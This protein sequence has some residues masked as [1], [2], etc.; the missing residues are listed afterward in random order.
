MIF[1]RLQFGT[2]LS[3]AT[4]L[5]CS[6]AA[7]QEATAEKSAFQ[8]ADNC[9]RC[10]RAP[11]PKDRQN[12]VTDFVR[13]TES[14]I[15][16]GDD[17]HALAFKLID[18]AD[19]LCSQ[20]AKRMLAILKIDDI[21][22]ARQCLSCHANWLPEHP[23][24]PTL[25]EGVTCESCHGPSA[26]WEGPHSKEDWRKLTSADKAKLG[27]VEIRNP[28]AR[29]EQCFSCHLG[30]AD[31]G[32]VVTHEMYAAGHPPLPSIEIESFAQQMPRHW[33]YLSEKP[34][35]KL[36][37][38]FIAANFPHLAE[39][40]GREMHRTKAVVLGGIAAMQAYLKLLQSQAADPAPG[41]EPTWPELA[42]FH[43]AACHHDLRP[44]GATGPRQFGSARVGR[45]PLHQW[46]VVLV[47]LG[48]RV[49]GRAPGDFRTAF[50]NLKAAA[51]KRPFGNS[52]EIKDAAEQLSSELASLA[53]ALENRPFTEADARLCSAEL[54][55]MAE[56]KSGG[57]GWDFH[58]AR[59]II[60][61]LRTIETELEAP[62]AERPEDLVEWNGDEWKTSA[63]QSNV[64]EP[65]EKRIQQAFTDVGLTG[66]LALD[67][68]AGQQQQII[69]AQSASLKAIADFDF[70]LFQ[71][72]M[73]ELKS[74]LASPNP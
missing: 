14:P 22:N 44:A 57:A 37:K 8:G 33:R 4:L 70:A 48:Y 29:A 63:W 11:L 64:R 40:N 59:Q 1:L 42:S 5:L 49:S 7:A 38:E 18:P 53:K 43:C 56:G 3:F 35:F 58:S 71:Q 20:P 23:R 31:E 19:P 73:R 51:A 30:N 21:H 27:M 34:D 52:A 60:W 55:S 15:W 24:P 72:Q 9:L 65:A 12:G 62:Y 61:A 32:K 66:L 67:L 41:S 2:A 6:V 16:S 54:F 50:V 26:A 13:L 45:P 46:P 28:L 68:P 10:H 69:A 74:K 36:R 47:S 17:K 39:T 25:T